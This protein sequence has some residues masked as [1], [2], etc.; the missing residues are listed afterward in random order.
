MSTL[1]LAMIL[2]IVLALSSSAQDTRTLTLNESDQG[3][4]SVEFEGHVGSMQIRPATSGGI[5]AQV[6]IR[7]SRNGN[8]R[9]RGNP[10]SME[11]R[12]SRQGSRLVIQL[13]G[14]HEDLEET[15][16]IE[17]PAHL[18]VEAEI[19]VGDISVQGIRGG[20]RTKVGVGS[21]NIDVPEGGVS[22]ETGVGKVSIRSGTNSYG[23]VDLSTGV[24]NGRLSIDG[25]EF[26]QEPR[27]PGPSE[28]IR[29]GG[30]GR[31]EFRLK[32]GVGDV[33]LT[34]GR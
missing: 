25:R 20:L 24:G 2:P 6:D 22:A 32:S 21:L 27:P 33:E 11:L 12:P 23:N 14:D 18:Q 28:R 17:V 1:A 10:Q 13:S 3:L 5:R 8:G 34:I 29:F 26:R 4:T 16:M 7:R 30:N 19:G 9:N 15:W 31:D